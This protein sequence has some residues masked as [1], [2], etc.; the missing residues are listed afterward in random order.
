LPNVQIYRVGI[1]E[2]K[3]KLRCPAEIESDDFYRKKPLFIIARIT[4]GYFTL[5]ETYFVT[6]VDRNV[7]FECRSEEKWRMEGDGKTGA[8]AEK[9][10]RA[11][12]SWK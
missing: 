6:I 1:R 8:R 3:I 9:K 10:G 5:L 2:Q 12:K 7:F 11:A 4:P